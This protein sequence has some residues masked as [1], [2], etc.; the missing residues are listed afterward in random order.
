MIT[1]FLPLTSA[2][3]KESRQWRKPVSFCRWS[4]ICAPDRAEKEFMP[5]PITKE[6][7]KFLGK[8]SLFFTITE[9]NL[10]KMKS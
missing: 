8:F 3:L 9:I 10:L 2:E 6:F 5:R 1:E 4:E 7:L